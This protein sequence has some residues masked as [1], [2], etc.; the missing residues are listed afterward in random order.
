MRIKGMKK[1]LV[2]FIVVMAGL[3]P[4]NGLASEM[5]TIEGEVSD[6]YQLVD[7]SGQFYE[8]ADTTQGNE[9]AEKHIGE[10]VRVTGTIEKSDGYQVFV[11]TSFQTLAE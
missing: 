8:I 10:K 9:L 7:G 5:V 1:V 11:V 4:L 3:I 6:N 2:L